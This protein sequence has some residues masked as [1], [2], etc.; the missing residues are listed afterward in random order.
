M[1]GEEYKAKQWF[2]VLKRKT[3]LCYGSL[4]VIEVLEPNAVLI[5]EEFD[6][7]WRQ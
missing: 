6:L 1:A 3:I 2:E 4:S 5:M 7:Y